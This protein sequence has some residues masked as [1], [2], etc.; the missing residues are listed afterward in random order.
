MQETSNAEIPQ[1]WFIFQNDQLLLLKQNTEKKLPTQSSIAELTPHFIRQHAMG[2]FNQISCIC[3]ELPLN[4]FFP[5]QFEAMPLRKALDLLGIDWYVAAT[6]AF[7][8]LNWDRNHQFCGRCGSVTSIVHPGTFERICDSCGLA[9]YPRISPSIIVLIKNEDKLL[10]SRSPHFP[11]GAYGLIAGF[12]ETGESVEEAVHREVREEVSIEIKNIRFFGSQFW[13][14]PD[15]LMIGFT[16]DYAGGEL[17]IDHR[18]IEAA[19]WYRYDDLPG[20]PSTSIS[21]AKKMI[22]SF[23]AEQTKNLR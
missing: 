11:P 20:R 1:H 17:I 19:G 8:I 2:E 7:S 4:L 23:I 5:E 6:K 12:V 21:I 3:A 16:A 22:D 10:M 15:S 13:P 14:F 9:L 18:E